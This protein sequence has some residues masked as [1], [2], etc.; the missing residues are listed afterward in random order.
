MDSVDA[1]VDAGVVED[2]GPQH[3][4]HI[5]TGVVTLTFWLEAVTSCEGWGKVRGEYVSDYMIAL[6]GSGR[7]R[8]L[9]NQRDS[10]LCCM[11][12]V[13]KMLV[14]KHVFTACACASHQ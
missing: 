4:W 8:W 1:G 5:A 6:R 9:H 10:L 12:D 3:L 2:A 11:E 13:G 7:G 14:I